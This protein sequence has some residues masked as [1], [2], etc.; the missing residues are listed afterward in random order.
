MLKLTTYNKKD[1]KKTTAFF[2]QSKGYKSGEVMREPSANCFEV[3]ID[4][5]ILNKNYAFYL[6]HSVFNTGYF[7]KHLKGSVIPYI[8][9]ESAINAIN[10]FTKKRIN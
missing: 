4:T 2:M 6:L 3:E 5:E 8:T 7:K 9:K 1:I 10:D